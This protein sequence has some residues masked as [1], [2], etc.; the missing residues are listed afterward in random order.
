VVL[1][2]LALDRVF[3]ELGDAVGGECALAS[4]EGRIR[5]HLAD[6]VL[7]RGG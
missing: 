5:R 6:G 7:D 1:I 4:L 3:R 2:E